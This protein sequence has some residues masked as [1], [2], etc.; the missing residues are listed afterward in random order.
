[1]VDRSCQQRMEL[2]LQAEEPAIDIVMFSIVTIAS[3][4][5][6]VITFLSDFSM[7]GFGEEEESSS[8]FILE[9]EFP[10]KVNKRESDK[11]IVYK[12]IYNI[13]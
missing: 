8:S 12:I 7:G 9:I 10:H 4:Q 3:L 1:M 6:T 13:Y 5:F 11:Y 2:N